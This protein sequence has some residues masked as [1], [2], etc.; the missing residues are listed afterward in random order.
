MSVVCP[1]AELD[2][3]NEFKQLSIF[4]EE[5]ECE[6][7]LTRKV[8]NRVMLNIAT[9][10]KSIDEGELSHLLNLEDEDLISA[11]FYEALIGMNLDEESTGVE[12]SAEWS[13]IVK[14][15]NSIQN[16]I[17]LTHDYYQ[18]IRATISKLKEETSKATKIIGRIKKL[19]SSPD[20]QTRTTGKI[21]VVYLDENER[22]KTVTVRLNKNDYD[23]AIEAHEKGFHVEIIG[24]IS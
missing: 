9:I 14:N 23:K 7:S 12:F 8:T 22:R 18:P 11:N 15:K 4:S 5:E 6:Q 13:P 16:K 3:S 19:E 17:L 20:L 24:E 10:K 21:T 2:E 1:F